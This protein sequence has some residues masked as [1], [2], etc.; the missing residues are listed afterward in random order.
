LAT[1][2]TFVWFSGKVALKVTIYDRRMYDWARLSPIILPVC[3]RIT[4]LIIS[5]AQW[6]F[7]G[8]YNRSS[9]IATTLSIFFQYLGQLPR[10]REVAY[11]EE[12]QP[13]ISVFESLNLQP[14]I[15]LTGAL[16][17]PIP[18]SAL[19]SA[20]PGRF[21]DIDKYQSFVPNLLVPPL[22][23]SCSLSLGWL[24]EPHQ[25][26]AHVR[27]EPLSVLK[28]SSDYLHRN[29][30]PTPP[31]VPHNGI[32]QIGSTGAA[33]AIDPAQAACGLEKLTHVLGASLCHLAIGVNL[34]QINDLVS[35]LLLL[36]RLQELDME[37]LVSD[38]EG[39]TEIGADSIVLCQLRRLY[40][41]TMND[42]KS[43]LP[44]TT[45]SL[46]RRLFS[47]LET[48]YPGVE[49]LTLSGDIWPSF[50]ATYMESLQALK[51]LCFNLEDTQYDH[52]A[53]SIT[54]RYLEELVV[55]RQPLAHC[56][57]TP[58]L[59]SLGLEEIRSSVD[60]GD[61]DLPSLRNLA[62]HPGEG[63]GYSLNGPYYHR[64]HELDLGVCEALKRV[65]ILSFSLL[66]SIRLAA[67][68]FTNPEGNRLC[69]ALLCHPEGCPM[70]RELH[71]E[72]CLEWD[73]LVLMLGRRN[74][75]LKG[76]KRIYTITLPFVPSAIRRAL[77]LLLA[78]E[79]AERP[80]LES[81]SLEE[82]REVLFD[83]DV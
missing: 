82:T 2:A 35:L 21:F 46:L 79:S 4:S 69:T 26:T 68:Y 71:F 43:P 20:T 16:S 59:L 66:A 24:F 11:S 34:S 64:L 39:P 55:W 25:I 29:L 80:A 5:G 67:R 70:L 37:I 56:L 8:H 53:C 52:N 17:V 22:F 54:L 33:L 75:G 14:T 31:S 57:Q 18:L 28:F 49:A 38:V 65:D 12:A 10:L 40:V 15:R 48:M 63:G 3:F 61:L 45:Q 41:T 30:F 74:F 42:R 6:G 76:V 72:R 13:R 32:S 51:F 60:L 7:S 81:L 47:V 78:G 9:G 23:R 50:A 58:N 19:S 36:P 73:I 62:I 83:A 44:S 77:L 1:L 27:E